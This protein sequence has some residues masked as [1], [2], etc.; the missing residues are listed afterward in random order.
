MSSYQ[1]PGGINTCEHVQEH[2]SLRP[3]K[4][5]GLDCPRPKNG[6]FYNNKEAVILA[7]ELHQKGV[8]VKHIHDAWKKDDLIPISYQALHEKIK[9]IEKVVNPN[10]TVEQAVDRFLDDRLSKEVAAR[11]GP[12]HIMSRQQ[13]ID[14]VKKKARNDRACNSTDLRTLLENADR[15]RLELSGK[16]P[17]NSKVARKTVMRYAQLLGGDAGM[18]RGEVSNRSHARVQA[19]QSMMH[20]ITYLFTTICSHVTV[21]DD[22]IGEKI[23]DDNWACKMVEDF[24]GAPVRPTSRKLILNGDSST[25]GVRL[26]PD[27]SK[28]GEFFVVHPEDE[29][30]GSLLSFWREGADAVNPRRVLDESFWNKETGQCKFVRGDHVRLYVGYHSDRPQLTREFLGVEILDSVYE[31]YSNGFPVRW[32]YKKRGY[33]GI[34][35][36]KLISK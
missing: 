5:Q 31:T 34:K 22:G 9:K 33:F 1:V 14:G 26:N 28:D 6:R 8:F 11:R 2:Y 18:L 20:L 27:G 15:E 30:S 25:I 23:P 36:G 3:F 19:A 21:A 10:F 7:R 17:G 24:W 16:N 12:K 35:M 4:I 32:P 13:F 29:L